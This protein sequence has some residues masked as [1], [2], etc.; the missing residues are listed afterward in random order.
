MD[1]ASY[2]A[3]SRAIA[4]TDRLAVLAGNVANLRTTGYRAERLRFETVLLSAGEPGRLA[5]VQ[6]VGRIRDLRPGP[7]EHT[8]APLDFAIVGN[9][10][11]TVATP[12][13]PAYTRAGH[14]TRDAEGRIVTS[15]GFPLLDENGSEIVLPEGVGA[16]TL[17]PDGLLSV[18]GA[19]PIARI[20]PVE[21]AD[22]GAL[23]HVGS[24]LYRTNQTP[25]P[26][27]EA[28]LVQGKLEGSNVEPVRELTRLVDTTRAF[29]A[30][31][32]MLETHHELVR[33]SSDRT[34]APAA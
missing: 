18:P 30:T 26:S 8:G 13:G 14:F 9:G 3:L 22:E 15:D 19:G 7:L 6:D 11:F 24:S 34:L 2:I 1:N 5:Y 12:Q 21:F 32:R 17:T 4:L 33:R 23:E 10:Y 20:Q 16:P 25:R 27:G 29:E 28:R 31:M